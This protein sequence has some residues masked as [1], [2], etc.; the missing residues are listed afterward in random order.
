MGFYIGALIDTFGHQNHLEYLNYKR[1]VEDWGGMRYRPQL[2]VGRDLL[3]HL[4]S[5]N[6]IPGPRAA[7]LSHTTLARISRRIQWASI[8]C[9]G[10]Y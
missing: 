5:K 1:Q 4:V 2:L 3:W 10:L 9:G 7:D 6:L 8:A